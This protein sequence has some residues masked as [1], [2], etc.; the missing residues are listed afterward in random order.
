MFFLL[1]FLEWMADNQNATSFRYILLKQQQKKYWKVKS[2]LIHQKCHITFRC[3]T[4]KKSDL[5]LHLETDLWFFLCV[6]RLWQWGD[7]PMILLAIHINFVLQN[8]HQN[9]RG[10]SYEHANLKSQ[11]DQLLTNR[12]NYLIWCLGRTNT[13]KLHFGHGNNL[14]FGCLLTQPMFFLTI[15]LLGVD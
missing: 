4:L 2:R 10:Y 15:Y 6:W 8:W 5:M 14:C 7:L 11:L 9:N 12:Q 1:T 3:L 13:H